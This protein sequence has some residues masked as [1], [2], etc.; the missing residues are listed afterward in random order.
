M[1]AEDERHCV[2]VRLSQVRE[3]IRDVLLLMKTSS[4]SSSSSS[5]TT[6]A[7]TT[8]STSTQNSGQHSG[9]SNG[10]DETIEN[11]NNSNVIGS[12]NG[13][14]SVAG[15]ITLAVG[16]CDTVAAISGK[17]KTPNIT[18]ITD[19]TVVNDDSYLLDYNA[20]VS[21]VTRHVIGSMYLSKGADVLRLLYE[22]P[23]VVG[24]VVLARLRQ[25]TAEFLRFRRDA[26]RRWK[27]LHEKHFRGLQD[28]HTGCHYLYQRAVARK[29]ILPAALLA[30]ARSAGGDVWPVP[31]AAAHEA[32]YDILRSVPM[33]SSTVNN[34]DSG[35]GPLKVLFKVFVEP[36]FGC[37]SG[38]NN[39]D[40]NDNMERV[41]YGNATFALFFGTYIRL[42]EKVSRGL[43]ISATMDRVLWS[44]VMN[45]DSAAAWIGRF[46]KLHNHPGK[47]INN[48]NNNNN[49][50]SGGGGEPYFNVFVDAAMACMAGIFDRQAYE[51]TCAGLFPPDVAQTL[52]SVPTLAAT[53]AEHTA[54]LLGSPSCD[55]LLAIYACEKLT[56]EEKKAFS[57]L[58]IGPDEECFVFTFT[59]DS[60]NSCNNRLSISVDRSERMNCG[61]NGINS[62]SGVVVENNSSHYTSFDD[63]PVKLG[64]DEKFVIGPVA[65]NMIKRS[66]DSMNVEEEKEKE[67]NVSNAEML[68]VSPFYEGHK[69]LKESNGS[70]EKE[71]EEEEEGD[72]FYDLRNEFIRGN[73]K[74]RRRRKNMN[75]ES[76]FGYKAELCIKM[77]DKT[78]RL[79]FVEDSECKKK[80]QKMSIDENNKQDQD[81][82]QEQKPSSSSSSQTSATN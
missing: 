74:R 56:P 54:A 14:T 33:F 15:T 17:P 65:P 66:G 37:G 69:E 26:N 35:S 52:Y 45:S 59:S 62:S 43:H 6:A 31:D 71:E 32:V 20:P 11:N 41:F 73:L 8:S 42:Y 34:D 68:E 81:Q 63:L 21:T 79:R 28:M 36:F 55:R 64:V 78:K 67:D 58:E 44:S 2:D 57:Q 39:N 82:K 27:A 76:K 12:G 60:E 23:A 47:D 1:D 25:K 4:S 19:P 80:I 9:N 13:G 38:S 16:T 18:G 29:D 70:E 50:N 7:T 3:A 77:S 61:S 10:N 51:D 30:R 46:R 5:S 75:D 49:N 22:R 40:S 24:P 48:N 53:L 72:D